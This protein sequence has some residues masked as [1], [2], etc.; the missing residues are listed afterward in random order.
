MHSQEVDGGTLYGDMLTVTQDML[1]RA[2]SDSNNF[3]HRRLRRIAGSCRHPKASACCLA[4]M[5][6]SNG[7]Q[8]PSI[9]IH[10]ED[11]DTCE[12]NEANKCRQYFHCPASPI[13]SL[14]VAAL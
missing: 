10:S 6:A 8:W 4:L 9:R 1:D 13:E 5:V 7:L 12:Q 2:A 11:I 14:M 3:L